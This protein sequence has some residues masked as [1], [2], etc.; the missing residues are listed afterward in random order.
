MWL[1]VESKLS[2]LAVVAGLLRRCWFMASAQFPVSEVKKIVF[3]FQH[4]RSWTTSDKFGQSYV[5][6]FNIIDVMFFD[7]ELSLA[8]TPVRP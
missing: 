7:M 4:L 1:K 2:Q 8:P 6:I 3:F 5:Y